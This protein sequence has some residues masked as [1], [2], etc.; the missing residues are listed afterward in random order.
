MDCS[1]SAISL[2]S[3]LSSTAS[4]WFAGQ[5]NLGAADSPEKVV[6]E[7][8]E[9]RQCLRR[10]DVHGFYILHCILDCSHEA[11]S[12]LSGLSSTASFWFAVQCM[13]LGEA[14]SPEE[15]GCRTVS[16]VLICMLSMAS[17]LLTACRTAHR[18]STKEIWFAGQWDLGA[19]GSLEE[20][21]D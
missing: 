4:F 7:P 11:I 8:K 2:L 13:N 3:G 1:H 12:L 6:T 21:G 5:W 14:D 19:A 20:G 16:N 17:M 9:H 15:G 10:N 18:N